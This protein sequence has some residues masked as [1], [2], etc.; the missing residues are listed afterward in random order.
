MIKKKKIIGFIQARMGSKRLPGKMLMKLGNFTILEWVI[1]RVSKAKLIDEV[2]LLTS[3]LKKDDVIIKVA[4]KL[5]IKTFRG[6]EINVLNRF[7]LAAKKFNCD[8]VV[9]ICADNPLVDPQEIDRL[10]NYHLKN[11]FDYCFNNQNKLDCNY[12]DGFGVEII[13][14]K[15]LQFL[16]QDVSSSFLR[17]HVTLGVFE[18]KY[19]FKISALKAPKELN[20]PDMKFDVDTNEDLEKLKKLIKIGVDL[21]STSA[22]I[23]KLA[24]T[25][26]KIT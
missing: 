19:K 16:E 1:K 17:E 4:N 3:S 24:I 10:I 6:S 13:N 9:R 11:K 18:K 5:G 8:V 14:N 23:I 12:A 15:I 22:D 20:Y 26:K 2:I 7:S 21:N 25:S